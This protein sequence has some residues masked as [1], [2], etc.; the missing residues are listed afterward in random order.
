M[1]TYKEARHIW[2]LQAPGAEIFEA[3]HRAE[4]ERPRLQFYEG[5]GPRST[6]TA[7]RGRFDTATRDMWAG[8]GVVLV[9]TDGARLESDWMNYESAADRITSTAPVTIT[10][11]QSEVKG[12]GWEARP[13]LSELIVRR[14]RGEIAPEDASLFRRP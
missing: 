6:V 5:S 12:I 1:D 8:G 3:D 11:G 14:Q 2:S 7:A 13:D 9:S 4:I 10:R